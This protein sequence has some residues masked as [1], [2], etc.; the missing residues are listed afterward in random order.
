M[1]SA[2]VLQFFELPAEQLPSVRID[3]GFRVHDTVSV[4]YDPLLAK[5]IAWGE[6][7]SAAIATLQNHV[8]P[9]GSA[10]RYY[11][12]LTAQPD[13]SPSTYFNKRKPLHFLSVNMNQNYSL[14]PSRVP[15]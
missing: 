7:R 4:Y 11:Q 3:S 8:K 12:H 1:P 10:W 9:N 5:L 13:Y 14:N 15:H 2:G 6:D